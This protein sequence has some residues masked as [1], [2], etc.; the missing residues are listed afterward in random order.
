MFWKQTLVRSKWRIVCDASNYAVKGVLEQQQNPQNEQTWTP[1]AFYS[2]K[3]QGQ[4]ADGVNFH[5]ILGQVAWTRREKK[6]YASLL[7]ATSSKVS[8]FLEELA[9]LDLVFTHVVMKFD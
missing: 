4:R 3:L 7:N 6:T 9:K 1:V 2:R 8:S 5:K